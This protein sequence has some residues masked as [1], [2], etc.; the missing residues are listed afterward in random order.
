MYSYIKD[1][2]KNLLLRTS[3][4]IPKRLYLKLLFRLMVGYKLHLNNP[5]T[6]NEKIQWLKLHDKNSLYPII[7]DKLSV[8]QYITQVLG[9]DYVFDTI[10]EWEKPEEINF[11][12]LPN[13][14]VLKTTHGGG[15]CGVIICKDK[16]RFNKQ[17]AV[18][19]LNASL[20]QDI[21]GKFLEW[22][23]SKVRPRILAEPYME[24][25]D[26]SELIDYKV[27]C[28]NGIPRF[29]LVCAGR[30]SKEGMT[31]DFYDIDWN[32]MN[33]ARVKHPNSNFEIEK[34]SCLSA[35]LQIASQISRTF[36]FLRV[37]F[38]IINQQLFIGELTLY[39]ASGFS[40]F[41]PS[42]MDYIFG[43]WLNINK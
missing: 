22:P 18:K 24:Q 12:S 8:K 30:N 39:P 15:N 20:I 36:P 21:G 16:S 14:F 6:F 3:R 9:S 31:E 35:M 17:L 25:S 10:G 42:K 29:I 28:F 5:R 43:E 27:H 40:P 2:T 13:R 7:V 34:P 1:R 11:T 4:I 37:D 33:C 41:I 23:Y 26:G 32:R 38:Y 19:L